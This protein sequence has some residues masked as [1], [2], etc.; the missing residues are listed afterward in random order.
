MATPWQHPGTTWD[1]L[2]TTWHHQIAWGT[3]WQPYKA[4][5]LA[6]QQPY[7]R[8]ARP[9]FKFWPFH[10]SKRRSFRP[11]LWPHMVARW[12]PMHFGGARCSLG[13]PGWSPGAARGLPGG[14]RA[15]NECIRKLR[16]M[17]FCTL[18]SRG[19][20]FRGSILHYC[21]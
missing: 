9:K 12:C 18:A 11:V 21:E 5:K 13:G 10:T 1:H 19:E 17:C 8:V 15:Q 20:G 14:F 7:Y 16:K 6:K 3:T 2:V 4:N